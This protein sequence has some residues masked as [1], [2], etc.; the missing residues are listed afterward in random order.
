MPAAPCKIIQIQ[1]NRLLILEG[2]ARLGTL[3]ARDCCVANRQTLTNYI[4][5]KPLSFH[6]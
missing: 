2:Q 1:I 5:V 6:T 4:A 3:V